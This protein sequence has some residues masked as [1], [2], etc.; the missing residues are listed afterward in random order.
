MSGL[1]I[2]P[3]LKTG[4]RIY[5]SSLVLFHQ[6]CSMR[7]AMVMKAL[8]II[9]SLSYHGDSSP[10]LCLSLVSPILGWALKCLAQG[11]SHEKT[12]GIQ[13]GSNPE[14]L[15]Y[16]TTEQGGTLGK[17]LVKSL[18]PPCFLLFKRQITEV[19]VVLTS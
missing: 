14:P 12:Q 17:M 18:P 3:P 2:N 19:Y 1:Y 10:Y 9:G 8:E 16:F 11:H 13:C 15:N 5:N 6:S 4:V 7:T